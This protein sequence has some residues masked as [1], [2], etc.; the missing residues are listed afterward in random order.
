MKSYLRFWG[1]AAG[2]RSNEP[3]WHPVAYH[4]LDVA[5]VADVLLQHNVRKLHAMARLLHTTPDNARRFLVCLISLHDI[6]KFSA[7]FQ[8]KCATAWPA[9]VLGAYEPK[10]GGRHDADGYA[11]AETLHLKQL[12]MPALKGWLPSEFKILW[13]AI[14]GHHGKW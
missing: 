11:M 14:T 3:V 1:K 13:A 7:A 10:A 9:D 12:L 4:C 2:E 6:G 5:A 8:S